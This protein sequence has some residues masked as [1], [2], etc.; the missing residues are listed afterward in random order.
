M[1]VAASP[2]LPLGLTLNDSARFDNFH[3][4]P[5]AELVEAL[6]QCAGGD[7]GAVL[8]LWGR[9]GS[10]KTHLLQAVCR[11]A[12]RRGRRAAY[13]PLGEA[14]NWPVG[15]LE[16]LDA[17]D[18]VC[19]DDAGSVAGLPD[20]QEGLFHLFNRLQA[21]GGTLV[22]AGDKRPAELGLLADL[23]SRLG[24]GPVYPLKALD[25]AQRLQALQ[26]R[27][28]GRGLELPAET[29]RYLLRRHPRDLPALCALLD[30]LDAASLA[31]QRRL[32]IPFV[33]EV[34]ARRG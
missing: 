24:W 6:R 2:Q 14:G 12:D 8:Y 7:C 13:L 34:L 5:N 4:G 10:G 19:L 20:W 18:L 28:R 25:D 1:V 9:R 23:A 33:R 15:M 22:A 30:R 17:L 26:L 16:G 11:E 21:R 3:A 32:T 31:A 29:G 27:A